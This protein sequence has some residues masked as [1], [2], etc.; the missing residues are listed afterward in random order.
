MY[1]RRYKLLINY[2]NIITIIIFAFREIEKNI[3]IN[4][5]IDLI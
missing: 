2:F 4:R 3:E 5:E 1:A